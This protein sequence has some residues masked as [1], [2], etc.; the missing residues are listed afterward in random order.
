M[1]IDFR[2]YVPAKTLTEFALIV[3]GAGWGLGT[4]IRVL[5]STGFTFDQALTMVEAHEIQGRLSR[6]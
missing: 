6:G 4:K 5:L 2:E 3:L 1:P